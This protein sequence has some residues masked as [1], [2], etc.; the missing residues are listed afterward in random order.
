MRINP[1]RLYRRFQPNTLNKDSGI[2]SLDLLST[3]LNINPFIEFVQ[4]LEDQRL[5]N[6]WNSI[7]IQWS[8]VRNELSDH[9]AFKRSK[10]RKQTYPQIH[11]TFDHVKFE[12]LLNEFIDG[13]L[14]KG[15][16]VLKCI[17]NYVFPK[18]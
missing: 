13:D 16:F 17:L 15:L 11:A 10:Y 5:K 6:I 3:Y 14:M 7:A 18:S 12:G 1:D 4:S 9:P 8:S 2:H